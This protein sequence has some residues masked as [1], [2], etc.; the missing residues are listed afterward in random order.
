MQVRARSLGAVDIHI[1]LFLNHFVILAWLAPSDTAADLY[2]VQ[3]LILRHIQI[4]EATLSA[5]SVAVR[6]CML[7]SITF[8][9]IL[10]VGHQATTASH[11]HVLV[12]SLGIIMAI[13]GTSLI[14]TA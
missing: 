6:R 7:E 11:H 3:C 12:G 13:M 9:I 8:D 2:V 1:T 5:H 4:V 14:K 10:L